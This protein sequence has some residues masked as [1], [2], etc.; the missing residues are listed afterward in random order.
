M[1]TLFE[2][3]SISFT[4]R[5]AKLYINNIFIQKFKLDSVYHSIDMWEC[6]T[7]ENELFDI[8][9][10]NEGEE[11]EICIYRIG[12]ENG[13][14]ITLVDEENSFKINNIIETF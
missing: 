9:L 12:I 10:Y 6:F 3:T 4:K 2:N 13:K 1:K 5:F 8:H 7:Y 14:H 11:P